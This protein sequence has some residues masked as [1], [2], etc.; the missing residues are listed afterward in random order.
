MRSLTI[1]DRKIAD[2]EP[3]YVIADLSHN[4]LGSA[5]MAREMIRLAAGTGCSAVKLQRRGPSTYIGLRAIG[6]VAYAD[7]REA[8]ELS[9]DDYYHLRDYARQCGVHFLV[10]VFD[11]ESAEEMADV[12]LDAVKLASGDLTNGPLLRHVAGMGL[13]IIISSGAADIEDVKGTVHLLT[14]L[15]AEFGLL[16]CT[17]EYPVAADHVNLRVIEDYRERFPETVIGFSSHVRRQWGPSLEAAAYTLGA[18]IIEKHLTLTPDI[19][20]G[21]HGFGL[22]IADLHDLVRTMGLMRQAVG[23][24]RKSVCNEEWLGG[25]RLGKHLVWS[26]SHSA[27]EAVRSQDIAIIGGGVGIGPSRLH[28]LVGATLARTVAD[29]EP[30][31]FD[32]VF[33]GLE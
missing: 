1:A 30:V 29:G 4:H 18:R 14:S 5:E 9:H 17:S 2:D 31:R 16:H 23:C 7:M 32:D 22:T 27:S 11:L 12:G 8:R 6:E 3:A 21:E 10:T 20:T 19:G 28:E 25:R 15:G 24:G 13:P 33:G 26:G